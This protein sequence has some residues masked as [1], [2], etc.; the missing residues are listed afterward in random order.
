MVT[1]EH[2]WVGSITGFLGGSIAH[3]LAQPDR[4][5]RT[6]QAGWALFL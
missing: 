1:A 3:L 5:H 6:N 4:L 2:G